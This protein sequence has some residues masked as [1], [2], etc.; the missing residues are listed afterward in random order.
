MVPARREAPTKAV[1]HVLVS[2]FLFGP[3]CGSFDFVVLSRI[4]LYLSIYKLLKRHLKQS[5]NP[6]IPLDCAIIVIITNIIINVINIIIIIF[7]IILLLLLLLLLLM[8]LVS[9]LILLLLRLLLLL[10]LLLLLHQIT[11]A[12]APATYILTLPWFVLLQCQSSLYKE[13]KDLCYYTM[14]LN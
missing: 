2:V 11:T 7:A 8:L 1:M 6:L 3:C 9:L 14:S 13:A 10:L 12:I 5:W 4:A